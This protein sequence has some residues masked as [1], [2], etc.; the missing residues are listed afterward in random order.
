MLVTGDR[1]EWRAWITFTRNASTVVRLYAYVHVQGLCMWECVCVCVCVCGGGGWEWRLMTYRTVLPLLRYTCT[2]TYHAW[3]CAQISVISSQAPIHV[4]VHACVWCVHVYACKCVC[5]CLGE[6]DVRMCVSMCWCVC[7]WVW[8]C[9]LGVLTWWCP[10]RLWR[11]ALLLYYC[12]QTLHLSSLLIHTCHE[13]T[14]SQ[15]VTHVLQIQ[16]H[17]ANQFSEAV[18]Y[19]DYPRVQDHT[20]AWLTPRLLSPL[21]SNLVRLGSRQKARRYTHNAISKGCALFH[22]PG[23]HPLSCRLGF[24]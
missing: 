6:Y 22:V 19:H 9:V 8:A 14:Q 13:N 10:W 17:A 3:V 2:C 23:T 20:C 24:C 7:L 1:T 11:W 21:V 18:H 5:V 16:L 12:T 15:L 4:H